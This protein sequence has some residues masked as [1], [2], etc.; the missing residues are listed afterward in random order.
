MS[1]TSTRCARA[2]KGLRRE[3]PWIDRL[4]TTLLR[5]H[6]RFSTQLLGVLEPDAQ[7]KLMAENARGWYRL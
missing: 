2:R 3:V 6:V 5:E 1:S 4:P 7:T